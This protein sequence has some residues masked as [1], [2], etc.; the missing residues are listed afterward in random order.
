MEFYETVMELVSNIRS[1]DSNSIY[2]SN[3][4]SQ[5]TNFIY[6]SSIRSRDANWIG[7]SKIQSQ[8]IIR[9]ADEYSISRSNLGRLILFI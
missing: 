5:D 3:I 1:R 8:D 6:R 9:S 7:K 2:R 4:R